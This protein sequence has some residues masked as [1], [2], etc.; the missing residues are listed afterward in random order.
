MLK[1]IFL[2]F[3][4]I[5][6]KSSAGTNRKNFS[7]K[8]KALNTYRSEMLAYCLDRIMIAELTAVGHIKLDIQQF[9]YFVGTLG[10]SKFIINYNFGRIKP[11]RLI[12]QF[13]L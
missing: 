11:C 4:Q 3:I 13:F 6:K 5:V 7:V 2:C 8:P 12:A 10:F 1:L 9:A